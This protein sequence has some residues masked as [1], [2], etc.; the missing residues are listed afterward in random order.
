LPPLASGGGA[1]EF[2]SLETEFQGFEFSRTRTSGIR[3]LEIESLKIESLKTRQLRR[4]CGCR[5]GFDLK[6]VLFQGFVFKDSNFPKNLISKDLD[7]RV[8][9]NE[10][11][12]LNSNP[13]GALGAGRFGDRALQGFVFQGISTS[14]VVPG[15]QGFLFKG[16]FRSSR[17]R[18]FSRNSLSKDSSHSDSCSANRLATRLGIFRWRRCGTDGD[19]ED[20]SLQEK[21]MRTTNRTRPAI[22]TR[23]G[24]AISVLQET[25]AIRECEEHG[26]MQDR[27]DPH[28]RA[29]AIDI[30]HRNP[31]PGLSPEA[32]AAEVREVIDSIGDTCPECPQ[33]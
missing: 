24:W 13:C 30:A 23:R 29:L 10:K 16:F 4:R 1:R 31:P 27:T 2:K 18:M 3:I 11:S 8:L 15:F 14:P 9:E 6:G 20:S 25:G 28:A 22:R 7:K 32:A 12:P 26:W 5:Q 19:F 33:Q 17:T 21:R